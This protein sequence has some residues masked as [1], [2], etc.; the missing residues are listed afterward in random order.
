MYFW[1]ETEIESS[2]LKAEWFQG[3]S[4]DWYLTKT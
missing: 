2:I 1:Y 4:H 3:A